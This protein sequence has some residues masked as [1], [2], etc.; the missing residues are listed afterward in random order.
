[1]RLRVYNLVNAFDE[2]REGEEAKKRVGNILIEF[3][4]VLL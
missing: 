2:K 1:M 3:N 4:L